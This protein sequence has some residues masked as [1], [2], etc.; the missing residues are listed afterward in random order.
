MLQN[1]YFPFWTFTFSVLIIL[2]LPTLLKD[3]M[4][5]DGLLYACISKNLSQGIGSFWFPHFSKTLYSF[6][7]QQPPLGFWIQSLFFKIFGENIYV[8]RLYSFSTAIITAFLIAVLWRI[9]F[10]N[11]REIKKLSWLPVLF[12]ITIPVCFWTYSNNM[13]ENTM[14]I[15]DLLAIIFIVQFIQRQSFLLIVL[16]GI[17][18]FLA[19]LTKGFQGMFPLATLFFGWLIY[20]NISFSKMLTGTL[21][22]SFIPVLFYFILLH[23]D[24]AYQSLTAYLNH[25]VINSIKNVAQDNRFYIL[26]RL[27]LELSPLILLSTIIVLIAKRTQENNTIPLKKH[28][29][30]YLLIGISASFPLMVTR[31]QSGFYLATSLPYYAILFAVIVTPYLSIW[32]EKINVR[33]FSFRAF[34]ILSVLSFAIALTFSF[35]QIGKTG[36][37]NDMIHDISLIGKIVPSGTTLGST[38][39]LWRDWSIQEYLIRHYYIC[40]DNKITLANDY[41]LLESEEEIPIG[42]KTQ[43]INIPTI[44]YHLFKVIK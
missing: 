34:G 17:F 8:E 37:D 35:S 30:F 28:T 10:K 19:S 32:I 26:F 23:N 14:G 3:G 11:E 21:L 29:S 16:S 41:L 20:R 38:E 33:L 13:L 36:R 4:F 44:K 31:E 15:F 2:T 7:D 43:K 27:F 18:I 39:K 22:L 25:R 1:K 9:V 42:V 5:M 24:S 12:W 40:Q 6:F